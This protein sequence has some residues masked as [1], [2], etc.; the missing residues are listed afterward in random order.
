M[1]LGSSVPVLASGALWLIL[2][3]PALGEERASAPHASNQSPS[4]AADAALSGLFGSPR[5]TVDP[6]VAHLEALMAELSERPAAKTAGKPGLDRAR[7]ELS[8]LRRM[9]DERADATAIARKKQ[10]VWAALSSSDRQM[11]RA[12]LA[13]ALRTAISRREAAEAQLRAAKLASDAHRA[14]LEAQKA[15]QTTEPAK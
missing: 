15:P 9:I 6:G 3:S 13:A 5:V 1:R 11:A 2:V 7:A 10:I 12:E 4:S 8:R 14:E